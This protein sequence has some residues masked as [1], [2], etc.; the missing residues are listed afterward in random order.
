M[1]TLVIL[2]T[3]QKIIVVDENGDVIGEAETDE[4]GKTILTNIPKNKEVKV[5]VEKKEGFEDEVILINIEDEDVPLGL[6]L[7]NNKDV[8][9]ILPSTG[10]ND[11]NYIL[12]GLLL[13]LA[14]VVLS[15]ISK[16]TNKG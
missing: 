5:I 14:G 3:T 9:S 11:Y 4:S 10:T 6:I 7:K 13:L 15:R 8:S 16:K 12:F 2:S 1:V